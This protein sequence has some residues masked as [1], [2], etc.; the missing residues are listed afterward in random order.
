MA[1]QFDIINSGPYLPNSIWPENCPFLLYIF[2]CRLFVCLFDCLSSFLSCLLSCQAKVH[3][4]MGS[5]PK[6]YSWP[7]QIRLTRR[8]LTEKAVRCRELKGLRAQLKG[9]QTRPNW[10]GRGEERVGE[11]AIVRNTEED[12]WKESWATVRKK[13]WKE[14]SG[15]TKKERVGGRAVRAGG[16]LKG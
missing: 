5:K 1:Q 4:S 13:R 6:F 15:L 10:D 2:S 7:S 9:W 16:L 8:R 14:R 11:G 3:L 12:I